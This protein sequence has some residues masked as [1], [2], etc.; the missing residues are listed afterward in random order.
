M[1]TWNEDEKPVAHVGFD[2]TP[3]R[4]R[5]DIVLS[6]D[7]SALNPA[8]QSVEPAHAGEFAFRLTPASALALGRRLSRYAAVFPWQVF[9]IRL[10]EDVLELPPS[11][12]R[13]IAA[14]AVSF[15][16]EVGGGHV[17]PVGADASSLLARLRDLVAR[18]GRVDG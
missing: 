10:C 5:L 7:A 1:T 13:Q 14:E 8:D 4:H 11:A 18:S 9:V 17:P 16:D 12:V 15:I 6:L 3:S 2:Y